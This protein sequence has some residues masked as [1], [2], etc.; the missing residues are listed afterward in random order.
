M[1]HVHVLVA[2]P[3]RMYRPNRFGTLLSQNQCGRDAQRPVAAGETNDVGQVT[4]SAS[5]RTRAGGRRRGEEGEDRSCGRE[6]EEGIKRPVDE[7]ECSEKLVRL[8]ATPATV[9]SS[10][11]CEQQVQQTCGVTSESPT[12]RKFKIITWP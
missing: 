8:T 9:P 11:S 5:A 10:G 1:E 6:G 12:A 4:T 2:L 7:T 3:Q